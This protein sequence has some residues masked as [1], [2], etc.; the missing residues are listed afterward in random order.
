MSHNFGIPTPST[1]YRTTS[2]SII[3][4]LHLLQPLRGPTL[5]TLMPLHAYNSLRPT[6]HPLYQYFVSR[7]LTQEPG[8]WISRFLSRRK[9]QTYTPYVL[10]IY[11]SNKKFSHLVQQCPKLN[12]RSNRRT[13]HVVKISNNFMLPIILCRLHRRSSP[14]STDCRSFFA[15]HLIIKIDNSGSNRDLTISPKSYGHEK[16]KI[17]WRRNTLRKRKF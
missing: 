10:V 1:P 8:P 15:S 17:L 14:R 6:P 4:T 12:P 16:W 11:L 13:G 9:A 7:R 2:D 3:F 5:P